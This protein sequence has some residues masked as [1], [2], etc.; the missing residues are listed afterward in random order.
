[1]FYD[2]N[3]DVRRL[4]IAWDNAASYDE[5]KD[6]VAKVRLAMFWVGDICLAL[7]LSLNC[8]ARGL[9]GFQFVTFPLQIMNMDKSEW[10]SRTRVSI[11]HHFCKEF[12]SY[13]QGNTARSPS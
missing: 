3:E 4:L 9:D 2:H 13:K 12:E 6:A 7:P 8:S 10:D 1:M 11:P 5:G